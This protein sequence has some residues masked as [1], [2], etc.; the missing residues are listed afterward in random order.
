MISTP[1]G[2]VIYM[3]SLDAHLESS[4][5][6]SQDYI[7]EIS[8]YYLQ[9]TEMLTWTVTEL[10]KTSSKFIGPQVLVILLTSIY[11]PTEVSSEI[12]K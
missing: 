1:P 3:K 6:G 9:N 10:G 2:L 12:S 8:G 5:K 4:K 11:S 7:K